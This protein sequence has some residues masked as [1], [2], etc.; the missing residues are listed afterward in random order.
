[1]LLQLLFIFVARVTDVSLGPIRM[2]RI[3]RDDK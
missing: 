3:I 1:M 2:I